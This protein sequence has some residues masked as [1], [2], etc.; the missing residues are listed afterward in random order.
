MVKDYKSQLQELAQGQ[1][2]RTPSYHVIGT[3]GPDHARLYTVAVRLGEE[4]LAIGQG[5]SKR[6]AEQQAA[7]R[8]LE[9]WAA[10]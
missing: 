5:P 2:Q 4:E 10:R 7:R 3:S 8:A 1:L 9:A 6:S